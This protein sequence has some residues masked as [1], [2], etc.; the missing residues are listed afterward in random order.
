MLQLVWGS[1]S[2]FSRLRKKIGTILWSDLIVESSLRERCWSRNKTIEKQSELGHQWCCWRWSRLGEGIEKLRCILLVFCKHLASASSCVETL[3][4][5][6]SEHQ[7]IE[8]IFFFIGN[9]KQPAW[10]SSS[11]YGKNEWNNTMPKF[12]IVTKKMDFEKNKCWRWEE[13]MMRNE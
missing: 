7:S 3:V 5:K 2:T 13:K 4:V 6:F 8:P 11:F 10:K 1:R 12:A 9:K